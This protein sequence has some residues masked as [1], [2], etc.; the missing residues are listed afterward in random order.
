VIKFLFLVTVSTLAFIGGARVAVADEPKPDYVCEEGQY[1]P[2]FVCRFREWT[3]PTQAP[4]DPPAGV[5]L[6]DQIPNPEGH[7]LQTCVGHLG[8]PDRDLKPGQSNRC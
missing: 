3:G 1:L 4:W 8:I 7:A 2:S 5:T 6:M